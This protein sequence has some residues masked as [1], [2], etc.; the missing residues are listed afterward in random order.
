M[1]FITTLLGFFLLI[2][3]AGPKRSG[4]W[5]SYD[6]AISQQTGQIA[7]EMVKTVEQAALSGDSEGSIRLYHHYI[8][9]EQER[10]ALKWLRLAV[11]QGNTAAMIGL[12]GYLKVGHPA[13]KME[14][15]CW[16]RIAYHLGDPTA[17]ELFKDTFSGED[18]S[19]YSALL[20]E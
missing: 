11:A 20:K 7:P 15:Q 2:S 18:L 16:Q 5:R 8:H 10:E 3:C 13:E 14:A 4:H 12:A 1:K 19:K 6:F 9:K 17:K